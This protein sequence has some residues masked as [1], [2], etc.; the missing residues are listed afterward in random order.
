M[1]AWHTH[2]AQSNRHLSSS[3]TAEV[4]ITIGIIAGEKT[5]IQRRCMSVGGRGDKQIQWRGQSFSYSTNSTVAIGMWDEELSAR[6]V[7]SALMREWICHE[8]RSMKVVS[9]PNTELDQVWYAASTALVNQ[10]RKMEQF[11]LRALKWGR[12]VKFIRIMWE[13]VDDTD[14]S[15]KWQSS[16]DIS[17]N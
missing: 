10:S 4:D 11:F 15:V 13:I 2:E 3:T 8:Q 7:P 9:S 5:R 17:C 14:T 6:I 16:G 1:V 12:T